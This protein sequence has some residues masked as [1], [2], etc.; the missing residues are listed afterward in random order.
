MCELKPS[1]GCENPDKRTD[2]DTDIRPPGPRPIRILA[3]TDIR[4][5]AGI[6]FPAGI[7]MPTGIRRIPADIR[8]PTGIRIP[9]DI[10]MPTGIRVPA[11]TVLLGRPV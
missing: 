2:T 4:I 8:M 6:R 11:G 9:A 5:S 3:D 7:R 1:A 10:R